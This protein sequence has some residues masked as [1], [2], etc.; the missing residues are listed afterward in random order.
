[1]DDQNRNLILATGLSFV[2]I[3]V[4]FL[5]FPPPEM[6]EDPNAIPPAAET[7]GVETDTGIAL[8]PPVTV[9]DAPAGADTT[10]PSEVALS[11]AARIDIDTPAVEGSISLLGGRIDDLSLRNYFT[12]VDGDQIVRLLSPVGSD[13][14]YYA[15]YGWTPS[16]DLGYA[17]VPTSDTPWELE[18]GTILTPDSPIT[19]AWDNGSGLIFRRTIEI[20][21]RFMFQV[22][23]SVENTGGAE[24]NLAPYGIV[25]RHGLP[26]DLQNFFIL[27]EGVVRKVDGELSELG[28]SDLPDLDII[29]R[30]GV[31]AEV[32]EVETNGWIGFTDKYWMTTLIPGENQSF[33]SVVKY[34][35]SAEIYQTEARLPYMSIAPG[36]TAEVTTQLFAGAKEAE[37]IR[38]YEN[39]EPGLI[40]SLF[41][42]E[43][44][45]SRGEIPRFIDSI[46]WGWFYFLTK[47]L[48]WLLHWLN[49]AI[50]NMGLAIISLTLIVKAV[51]FP[52]AYRSYVSMAKMKELQPEIEKLKESAGDD[53]QKLQQ[54]MMELYKKN[55][56]N[57]AGGCLPILLQIP[58][59]FS[60]YKVIFVTLE[61][62]HAPFFGWLNDL[63]A[64][65][66]SSII[67]LYGLLP[68]PAPEPE[69]IMALIFIGILPL[70]LGIS[71]WL[72]Q[73]LNPAPTDAMQAQIFAWLPWVFMFM[74]GSFASGLLVYW[75]ANNTL[76][77]TQQYLIMR[78]QGFKPDVF[79]NIRSSF[80][81]KAKEEK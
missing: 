71:M 24:V 30:E 66:S 31:P 19:L 43:Q 76:T 57:P 37:A 26:S 56:V 58:I 17:D 15:L 77:F 21:D 10:A 47:P 73:K 78:S 45:A 72:Q 53:R 59:F 29:A 9:A 33:V 64:P 75:I 27:H 70:L 65:D 6:V 38:D 81:K 44:D 4:W 32:M 68:N 3:L 20:D 46:D 39:A 49:G 22:T 80:K 69:S 40:A 74:L 14:P 1:M 61:L 48:F 35:P 12:E 54:G 42:A 2:V 41:G 51:L 50:G 11:E 7:G 18:S 25:A 63:S 36:E 23:Q 52:L 16:G 13:D 60:L 67:N 5:L 8:T 34:V 55:K 79:G 62:R 28:Y